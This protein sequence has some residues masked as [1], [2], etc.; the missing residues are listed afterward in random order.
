L[1][2]GEQLN[3]LTMG[4][5]K[6][7]SLSNRVFLN[8]TMTALSPE[9][10]YVAPEYFNSDLINCDL[11]FLTYDRSVLKD[12]TFV[13]CDLT[14]AELAR[15][16]LEHVTFIAC[17]LTKINFTGSLLRD[18]EIKG[19]VLTGAVFTRAY[20]DGLRH[21]L[22]PEVLSTTLLRNC[23]NFPA[24]LPAPYVHMTGYPHPAG[25]FVGSSSTQP[26]PLVSFSKEWAEALADAHGLSLHHVA[27]LLAE[28]QELSPSEITALVTALGTKS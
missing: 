17:N 5:E 20:I 21:D 22:N 9:D 10:D 2:A 7:A 25:P 16:L 3:H 15:T 13:G 26:V 6:N 28:H 11:R 23:A 27:T 24:P 4:S 1:V 19:S 12:F 8:C 14:G 18:V